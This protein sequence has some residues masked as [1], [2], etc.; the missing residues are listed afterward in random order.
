M[1]DFASTAGAAVSKL[2]EIDQLVGAS[3]SRFTQAEQQLEQVGQEYEGT[4]QAMLTALDGLI[5]PRADCPAR[6]IDTGRATSRAITSFEKADHASRATNSYQSHR[7]QANG[8][9][10]ATAHPD[11]STRSQRKRSINDRRTCCVAIIR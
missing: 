11:G 3:Q 5:A 4:A 1:A 8:S 6:T 7:S 10:I 2:Q 9:T